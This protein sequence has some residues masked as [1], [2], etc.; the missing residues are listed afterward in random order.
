MKLKTGRRFLSVIMA[1]AIVISLGTSNAFATSSNN[2]DD[3]A[4]TTRDGSFESI[5]YDDV[6]E[7]PDGG[8]I[9]VYKVDGVTHRFPLPPEDFDPITATDEQLETYGIPPRPDIN[10]KDDYLSWV[11]IVDGVD[12]VPMTELKVMRGD[13]SEASSN[14]T[15]YETAGYSAVS[16][17]TSQ[18][19]S[20]Y[21]SSLSSSSSEFYNQVQVD[22][23]EPTVKS[24]S[25]VSGNGVWI[26]LGGTN[27]STSLVQAGTAVELFDPNKH[28][29]W[30][31]C[32][33]PGH[34]NPPQ[35]IRGIDVN[36]RDKI[37]IYISFQAANGIFNWYVVNSTTEQALSDT[38][39]YDSDIYFDGS[40]VEWIVER[41][42]LTYAD[43]TSGYGELGDYG[44]VTFTNC[45]A[46]LNTSTSWIKL[47][48]LSNVSSRKM[49][50]NGS[51]SGRT[52]S[53]PGS[54]NGDT[55]TCYWYNYQ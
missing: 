39:E 12:F 24:S 20:G 42:L 22:Y 33:G 19:W 8:K 38:P 44:S 1:S 18:S 23:V 35:P 34:H 30:F 51:S 16:S 50:S 48:D 9:Y 46:M 6:E 14:N 55:F 13:N 45:K 5:V 21:V 17:R 49:T 40:T 31:E 53:S 32:L 2:I 43:G 7:L 29:A 54:I 36:P 3:I 4:E 47:G 10:D 25:G 37:H 41:P 27:G 15:R 28:Y 26:G 11:E 52:L